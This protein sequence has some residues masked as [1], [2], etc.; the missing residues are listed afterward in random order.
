MTK[1]AFPFHFSRFLNFA[2]FLLLISFSACYYDHEEELYQ[3]IQ[4]SQCD[5]SNVTYSGTIKA[6][7]QENCNS[8]HNQANPSGGIA[9]DNYA[10]LQALTVNGL[11]GK[12]WG[13]LNHLNGFSPM[14]QGGNKLND[15]QL[16]KVK[17]WI[18]AGAPNN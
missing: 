4:I 17:A 11:N 9:T 15:C 6:I 10:G 12:L 8:C 3:N 16:S 13:V 5:T 14:P 2:G 1:T 7:M 18:N